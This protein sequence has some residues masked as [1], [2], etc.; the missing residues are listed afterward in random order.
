MIVFVVLELDFVA[1]VICRIFA[2]GEL[3]VED[4][5]RV[6]IVQAVV[7]FAFL[8]L[9]ADGCGGVIEASVLEIGLLGLLHLYDEAAVVLGY[10]VDIEHGAAVAIAF[11]EVFAVQVLHVLYFPGAVVKQCIEETDKQVLVHLCSEQLFESEVG[12]RINVFFFDVVCHKLP[13]LNCFCKD[14]DYFSNCQ[15]IHRIFSVCC[16]LSVMDRWQ[17]L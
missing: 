15:M 5:N 6:D 11:A 9:L 14:N 8:G 4:A 17:Q 16:H 7:P 3:K 1:V 2:V 13:S 12:I 10:T